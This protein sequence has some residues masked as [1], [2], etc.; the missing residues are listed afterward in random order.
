M[1]LPGS[2]MRDTHC[3]LNQFES[4]S[5]V[6]MS[7]ATRQQIAAAGADAILRKPFDVEE[8]EVLLRRFLGASPCQVAEGDGAGE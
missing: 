5:I 6:L 2:L 7:A 3:L 4:C 8:V 1:P